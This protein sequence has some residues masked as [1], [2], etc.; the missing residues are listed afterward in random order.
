MHIIQ[1]I[2]LLKC[3]SHKSNEM[4]TAVMPDAVFV[5]VFVPFVASVFVLVI[6]TEITCMLS[7]VLQIIQSIACI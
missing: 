3:I 5:F 6:T 1:S 4:S 2:A 7:V